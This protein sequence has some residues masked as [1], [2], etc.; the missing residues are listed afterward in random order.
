[1][2]GDANA[3]ACLD[4]VVGTRYDARELVTHCERETI[5]DSPALACIRSWR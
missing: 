2:T 4:A 1:M 3:L 5:G